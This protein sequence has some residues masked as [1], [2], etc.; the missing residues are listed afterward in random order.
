MCRMEV[1]HREIST[2]KQKNS[3]QAL[4]AHDFFCVLKERQGE[5]IQKDRIRISKQ[6]RKKE[7]NGR[8]FGG[9]SERKEE[10]K[11]RR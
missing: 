7:K 8:L 4:N 10:E 6:R 9:K 5:R 2:R 3:E 11:E 1:G